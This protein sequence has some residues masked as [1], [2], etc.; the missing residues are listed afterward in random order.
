MQGGNL[1]VVDLHKGGVLQIAA[2]DGVADV[3]DNGLDRLG[4]L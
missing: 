1:Q 2:E 3:Y 4:V